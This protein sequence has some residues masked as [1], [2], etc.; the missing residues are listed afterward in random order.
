MILTLLPPPKSPFLNT[1]L[2]LCTTLLLPPCY[3]ALPDPDADAVQP[4][5][6]NPS[7]STGTIPAFPEQADAAGCPLSLSDEHYEGIKSACGSNKHAADDDDDLHRSRCCPVLAAWLYSAYSATALS[8]GMQHERASKG[9]TTSYDMPLLPDD[10]ET[11]VSDL[12]KAL[13]IR[14]I[15]L[16][17]P[18]ET[19][20]LVYCYCGIRLH[21]LTC[22]E[23]FS[24][25]PSGTLVVNQSVK[26]LE[27][28][29]FSSS[30]NVNKFPGL[31]GCSKCLHSLYSLRKNS[32]NSSKSED[33]TT[34]IHN[35]D[36]EL[37]GLTW[38]LA[39]NRTAYIHTVSGVLRALML[40][41][42]GSDPQ[43]CTLNSDGMPLAVDS[44]E[45]SDESSSTN[46]QAP[47]FLSLLLFLHYFTL[48]WHLTENECKEID[49]HSPT[50]HL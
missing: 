11:C 32:S 45:M 25:T 13:K 8:G 36:C 40:S 3:L 19:C 27:R 10:S 44:S 14:G 6:P 38:L 42:E 33:R 29:C 18:N 16:F 35:K 31:G 39:K 50:W 5:I 4:I 49:P 20:D 26:R 41:T 17:Q 48:L 43:S 34:K 46:L 21:P 30:T 22:P 15:Q 2:L 23:S 24:V 37:M 9:H 12:G 47:I 7:S 1:L 28:D